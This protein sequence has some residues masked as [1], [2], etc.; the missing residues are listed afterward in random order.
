MIVNNKEII[1]RSRKLDKPLKEYTMTH[2]CKKCFIIHNNPYRL[3]ECFLCQDNFCD[4]CPG[5][6]SDYPNI[7]SYCSMCYKHVVSKMNILEKIQVYFES[8]LYGK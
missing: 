7:I 3:R 6:K 8:Y 4:F 2:S 1:K 5:I